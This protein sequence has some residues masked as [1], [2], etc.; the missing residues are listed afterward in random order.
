VAG[1]VFGIVIGVLLIFL[2][3]VRYLFV[4]R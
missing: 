3:R 2:T 1:W 4:R